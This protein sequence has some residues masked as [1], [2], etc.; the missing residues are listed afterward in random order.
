MK[1]FITI[2]KLLLV[3]SIFYACQEDNTELPP[4]VEESQL[5]YSVSDENVDVANIGQTVEVTFVTFGKWEVSNDAEWCVLDKSLSSGGVGDGR[6]SIKILP[7]P[8]DEVI[9]SDKI[10][11]S[12]NGQEKLLLCTVTQD[13]QFNQAQPAGRDVNKWISQHMQNYY[14]W[15][16]N[17]LEIKNMLNFNAEPNVFLQNALQRMN[18]NDQDGGVLSNGERYYYSN[19]TEFQMSTRLSQA[20]NYGIN[21]VYTVQASVGSYYLL[22]ASVYPDSPAD[23]AGLKRGMYIT[24]YNGSPITSY[25]LEEAYYSVMG[26]TSP[27]NVLNVELAEY[28]ETEAGSGSYKLTEIGS[29]VITPMTYSK[30]PIIYSGIYASQSS[31][32]KVGYLVYSDF[33]AGADTE[34][35]KAFALLKS[36]GAN[37]LILDLRY[38][39]G[40]D[41][42]SSALMATAIV[43]NKHKGG[44]Y[45]EMEF[46]EYRKA[47]GEKEFF[48]IGQE[49]SMHKYPLMQEALA[50]SLDLGRVY[51]I[52]SGLTASA[53]ELVINGLRGLGVD[54]YVVGDKTEGKNVGME[55]VMSTEDAFSNY[56]FGNYAYY[57][58]AITFYNKNALGFKDYPNG[59]V[60]DFTYYET[61]DILFDW[62]SQPQF[63]ACKYACI[64]H[65]ITGGWP[66]FDTKTRV[67][68]IK[69]QDALEVDL[70]NQIKVPAKNAIVMP[71]DY[72]N[73]IV[74]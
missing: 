36:N 62:N 2:L 30:N 10:W 52:A 4:L 47:K 51:V 39:G 27:L 60:P 67:A 24:T 11:I 65:I 16:D 56:D 61:K 50:Q 55:V 66:N 37:E 54:V 42:I 71:A 28:Q 44:V 3:G 14:L 70:N 17:Y 53:S 48:Y 1:N 64:E 43:G 31:D 58:A 15:N 73:N 22:V 23:E 12:I 69:L 41:V 8:E 46:N 21:Q 68:S 45:C 49:P 20:N 19:I 7:N 63:D 25:N 32:K 74:K 9:R 40:G 29:K 6:I 57:F 35:M 33:D 72:Y 18:R 34:L 13:K 38:N 26:Y 5:V 59:F